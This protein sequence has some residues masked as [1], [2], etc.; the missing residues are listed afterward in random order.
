MLDDQTA[1]KI[2]TNLN[3]PD[4]CQDPALAFDQEQIKDCQNFVTSY[5]PSSLKALFSPRSFVAED[6]CY[7]LFS[8]ANI[9]L[10]K[11]AESF[12]NHILFA[13]F[14]QVYLGTM[15]NTIA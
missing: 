3:G 2:V 7:D 1:L 12:F 8:K 6:I 11:R 4:F 13:K 15:H 5:I 14:S 10:K 9:A